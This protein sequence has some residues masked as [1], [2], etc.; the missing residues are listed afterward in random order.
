MTITSQVESIVW[1][2]VHLIMTIEMHGDLGPTGRAV[3]FVLRDS[4][5]AV[6]LTTRPLDQG[7]FEARVNVTNAGHRQPLPEGAWTVQAEIDGVPGPQATYRLD[8]LTELDEASRSFLYNEEL[9]AYLVGFTIRENERHPDLIVQVSN[10]SRRDPRSRVLSSRI[11]G[12]LLSRRKA[13]ALANLVYWLARRVKR[14][15]L[16]R[17]LFASETRPRLEGNLLRVRDRLVERGL[18]TDL[19]LDYS[20]R[21]S[22]T[23]TRLGTVCTIC[24]LAAADV[25]LI[26]DYFGILD[27]MMLSKQTRVIQLW[28]AGIGFKSIGFSRFGRY[29]TPKLRNAHRSYDYAITGSQNLIPTYA[30]AFGIDESAIVATG[31]PR[32]DTFLDPTRTLEVVSA[33]HREHHD[34]DGRRLVLFAPTFRGRGARDAYYDYDRIDFAALYDLCGDDTAILFRMHHFVSKPVPIPPEFG[35]RLVDVT[36]HPNGNDLLH[37]TDL[38]VT[39]YSSIVYEFSLLD[40]PMLFFAYDKDVYA[41]LRGFHRD[42]VASAP[43]KVCTT[44]EALTTAIRDGDF[45]QWKVARFRSENFDI[46]DTGSTDRVID[47]LVLG[48]P[49]GR[50][51]STEDRA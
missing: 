3:R 5:Q 16:R 37:V 30:E 21:T 15:G 27:T 12:A 6:P 7:R 42:Y 19:A 41:A 14:P 32:L 29:G 23:M 50:V 38:L 8:A 51:D 39:D 44:F 40:R 20:F 11:R 25:I 26:D 48:D 34:L 36:A 28:H 35:D 46:V 13:A 10:M 43:G 24:R 45:E 47:W 31:L 18:D 1:D 4:D 9:A 17:I 22:G 2:R 49:P 33:F